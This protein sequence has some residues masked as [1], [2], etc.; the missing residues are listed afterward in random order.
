L[1]CSFKNTSSQ[2]KYEILCFPFHPYSL[3]GMCATGLAS[4]RIIP[5]TYCHNTADLDTPS[6][7]NDTCFIAS[8]S[9]SNPYV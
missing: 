6:N 2:G 8:I 9:I 3:H 5:D 4:G 7:I 1:G